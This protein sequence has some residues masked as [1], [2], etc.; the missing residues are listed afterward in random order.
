MDFADAG[1]TSFVDRILG[2]LGQLGLKV[3]QGKASMRVLVVD[4]VARFTVK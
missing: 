2:S 1:A 3:S 4:A